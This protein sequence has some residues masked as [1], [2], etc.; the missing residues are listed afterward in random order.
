MNMLHLY[1]YRGGL[2]L[3]NENTSEIVQDLEKAA[4][5]LKEM[6]EPSTRVIVHVEPIEII[7]Q[8]KDPSPNKPIPVIVNIAQDTPDA[9]N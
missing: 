4:A 3:P 6:D 2:N 1:N 8:P 5:Y 9:G 7:P